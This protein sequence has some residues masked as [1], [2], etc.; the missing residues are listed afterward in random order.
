[1]PDVDKVALVEGDML[2]FAYHFLSS[3]FGLI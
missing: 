1:V 2:L 3:K